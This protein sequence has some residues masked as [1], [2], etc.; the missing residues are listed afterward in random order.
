MSQ[1]QLVQEYLKLD[2]NG[3]FF[4]GIRKNARG[5]ASANPI[6]W[7]KTFNQPVRAVTITKAVFE[8]LLGKRANVPAVD[9]NFSPLAEDT[10]PFRLGLAMGANVALTGPAGTGKSSFVEQMSARLNRPFYVYDVNEDSR[11]ETLFGQFLPVDGNKL[12]WRDGPV[13][14]AMKQE[15][16]F[17]LLDEANMAGGAILAC[18]HRVLASRETTLHE[19]NGTVVKCEPGVMFTM[20]CNALNDSNMA[21]QYADI[22]PMNRAFLDRFAVVIRT[23]Y[24]KEKKEVAIILKRLQEQFPDEYAGLVQREIKNVVHKIVKVANGIRTGIE[25][26]D[27]DISFSLR[28]TMMWALAFGYYED[29]TQATYHSILNMEELENS[30]TIDVMVHSEFG[31]KYNRKY[32][33]ES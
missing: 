11:P 6:I 3:D 31:K 20:A 15:G 32:K 4:N 27:L 28:R 33:D 26:G 18:M 17:F 23:G 21:T 24:P 30:K 29:I 14:S 12:E 13:T 8:R 16:A 22:K 10:D 7:S 19:Q 1:S 25:E 9:N 5:V 2:P